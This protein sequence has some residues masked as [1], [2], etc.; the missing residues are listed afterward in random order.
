MSFKFVEP[1][2]IM[3]TDPL[4]DIS[5]GRGHSNGTN[6]D[7]EL[8][9]RGYITD[10]VREHLMYSGLEADNIAF[11]I[12]SE[13]SILQ[14]RSEPVEEVV[15]MN[16]GLRP[17]GGLEEPVALTKFHLNNINREVNKDKFIYI[18]Y[19]TIGGKPNVKNRPSVNVGTY[20]YWYPARTTL[21]KAI[22]KSTQSTCCG[23]S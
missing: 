7:L 9:R 15:D 18:K 3:Q 14:Q 23:I 22:L 20:R 12:R 4:L 10:K 21:C 2:F 13:Q 11:S 1:G 19:R 17:I 6:Y 5:V 16:L 8:L